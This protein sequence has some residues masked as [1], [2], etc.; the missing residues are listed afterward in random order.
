MKRFIVFNLLL[1]C[2]DPS[3]P[4]S[5]PCQPLTCEDFNHALPPVCG[6]VYD[7][8]GKDLDCGSCDPLDL[9]G[10]C[11]LDSSCSADSASSSSNSSTSSMADSTGS[12]G[13]GGSN[14][15]EDLVFEK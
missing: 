3:P 6:Q 13:S 7:G 15:C 12:S 1:A 10:D 8:C 4:S 2:S 11:S 9:D 5:T 14:M